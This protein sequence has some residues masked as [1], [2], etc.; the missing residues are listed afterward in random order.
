M[1]G[2]SWRER[3]KKD[4]GRGVEELERKKDD[5][6]KRRFQCRDALLLPPF[7]ACFFLKSDSEEAIMLSEKYQIQPSKAEGQRQALA[8]R[9]EGIV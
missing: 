8:F 9:L 5:E 6:K 3:E 4:G 7:I 2:R 1:A